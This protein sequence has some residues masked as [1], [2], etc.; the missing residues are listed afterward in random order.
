MDN[1]LLGFIKKRGD[2]TKFFILL[3]FGIILIFIG[4][5][6]DVEVEADDGIE[7]SLARACS[8]VEGVGECTVLVNYTTAG[9]Y[10]EEK[11]IESVLVIC[12]GAD[13]VDVRLRLTEMLSS[14]F[15]IGAN[16]IRV[17]KMRN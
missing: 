13:S 11:R 10:T 3:L 14:F 16:R 4:F 8:T 9:A 5:S 1:K 7:V 2:V 17:E 6:R 15:G 12:E